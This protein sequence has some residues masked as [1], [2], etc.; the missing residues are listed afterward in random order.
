MHKHCIASAF[1]FSSVDDS[2]LYISFM[3]CRIP[4]HL[5]FLPSLDVL[6]KISGVPY[7]DNSDIENNIPNP[8]NSKYYYFHD[9]EKVTLSCYKSYFSLV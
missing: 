8:I 2:E 4:S 6:S 3:N 5:E 9:F 7:L 1:P